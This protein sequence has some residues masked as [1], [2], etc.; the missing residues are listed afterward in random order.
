LAYRLQLHSNVASERE[1]AMRNIYM[2][3]QM[4]CSKESIHVEG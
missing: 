4:M 1:I 2:T 3:W